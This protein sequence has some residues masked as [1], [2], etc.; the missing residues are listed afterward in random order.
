MWVIAMWLL[1]CVCSSHV[2]SLCVCVWLTD[3]Q[4][5]VVKRWLQPHVD[6]M[7]CFTDNQQRIIHSQVFV[8]GPLHGNIKATKVYKVS[9]YSK[10]IAYRQILAHADACVHSES[11]NYQRSGVCLSVCLSSLCYTLAS[12]LQPRPFQC[13]DAASWR[14]GPSVW[15]AYVKTYLW[16]VRA[17][18][19]TRSRRTN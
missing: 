9:V 16:N 17:C 1:V 15:Y 13:H 5:W 4:R 7:Y 8:L 10:A 3:Q 14:F 18:V 19:C 6:S 11:T 2:L 12:S